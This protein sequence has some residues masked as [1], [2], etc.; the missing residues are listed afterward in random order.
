MTQYSILPL[1]EGVQY[2]APLVGGIGN[3]CCLEWFY[4]RLCLWPSV[5]TGIA[6]KRDIEWIKLSTMFTLSHDTLTRPIWVRYEFHVLVLLSS[7]F[8]LKEV[9]CH[10]HWNS[11]RAWLTDDFFPL[12]SIC[13][14]LELSIISEVIYLWLQR[15]PVIPIVD[16]ELY[17]YICLCLI[18]SELVGLC[19]RKQGHAPWDRQLNC[20]L[21]LRRYVKTCSGIWNII[22]QKGALC[23]ISTVWGRNKIK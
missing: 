17:K 4:D 1:W 14:W 12:L 8:K 21:M 10:S 13:W 5:L 15:P 6:W 16:V 20:K 7:A 2:S 18:F 19:F 3:T 23:R 9:C 22:G 11:Y